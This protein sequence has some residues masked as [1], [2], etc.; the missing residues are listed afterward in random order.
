MIVCLSLL[1]YSRLTLFK[2]FRSSH[3]GQYKDAVQ[4]MCEANQ[5]EIADELFVCESS[6]LLIC[7]WRKSRLKNRKKI[8]LLFIPNYCM[9]LA[10]TRR[11]LCFATIV[12]RRRLKVD[13][14]YT[15]RLVDRS[16]NE[17]NLCPWIVA[18]ISA[19]RTM[20]LAHW[21][22]AEIRLQSKSPR[23]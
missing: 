23:R 6:K 13:F 10:S 20:L 14:C 9:Q 16:C 12:S 18:A 11:A 21:I 15:K 17:T 4:K 22:S 8:M 1:L 19:T 3:I 7:S 2:G 5:Y